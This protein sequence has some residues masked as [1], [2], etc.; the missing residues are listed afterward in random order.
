M[1]NRLRHLP[2]RTL[3]GWGLFALGGA[4]ALATGLFMAITYSL[5]DPALRLPL[6][7]A[8]ALGV[9]TM[10]GAAATLAG[11]PAE[12][13]ALTSGRPVGGV[14]IGVLIGLVLG[15]LVAWMLA[16]LT[17]APWWSALPAVLIPLLATATT[18]VATRHP[19][20]EGHL[21]HA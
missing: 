10:I 5:E 3:L 9:A 6:I 1:L 11:A 13:R 18:S 20:V 7:T 21:A 14:L 17:D 15:L 16:E 4:V 2:T 8:F 12:R 19:D